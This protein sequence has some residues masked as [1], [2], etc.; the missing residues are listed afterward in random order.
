MP[1]RA[2]HCEQTVIVPLVRTAAISWSRGV[3]SSSSNSSARP[4]TPNH[5]ASPVSHSETSAPD[6]AAAAATV[7]PWLRRSALLGAAGDLDDQ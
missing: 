4:G 7:K 3:A 6:A 1:R 5:A 2:A